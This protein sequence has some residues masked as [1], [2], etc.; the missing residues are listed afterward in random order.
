MHVIIGCV[1]LGLTLAYPRQA[2]Q[3]AGGL[4]I[5]GALL[6]IAFVAVVF[7]QAGH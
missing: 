7:S 1:A 6:A 4:V 3:I 2:A 5:L